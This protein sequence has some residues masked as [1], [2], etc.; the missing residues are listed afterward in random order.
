MAVTIRTNSSALVQ[1]S[2]L[3]AA[4]MASGAAIALIG[5]FFFG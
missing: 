2:I 3:I 1:S 5:P 4:C